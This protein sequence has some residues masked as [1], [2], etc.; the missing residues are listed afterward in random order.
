MYPQLQNIT[1][2]FDF[3]YISMSGLKLPK[4]GK[5]WPTNFFLKKVILIQL[6]Q[7]YF[8]HSLGHIWQP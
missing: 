4:M 1:S 6:I 5:L 7:S 2:S 3:A 8:Y